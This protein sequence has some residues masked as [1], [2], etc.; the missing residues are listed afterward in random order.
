MCSCRPQE[1]H[2][3]SHVHH[4]IVLIAVK[5]PDRCT[6]EEMDM[7]NPNSGMGRFVD[8]KTTEETDNTWEAMEEIFDQQE[9]PGFFGGR[10]EAGPSAEQQA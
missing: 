1:Q 8:D 2:V 10:T 7:F 4:A 6:A 3:A 9:N 5:S